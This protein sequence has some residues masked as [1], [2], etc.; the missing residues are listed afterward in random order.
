MS[1][2][3]LTDIFGILGVVSSFGS[4]LA[5]IPTFIEIFKGKSTLMFSIIPYVTTIVANIFWV[6]FGMENFRKNISLI[7]ANAIQ[8]G[9]QIVYILI[10]MYYAREKRSN[11]F[12]IIGGLVFT[13]TTVLLSYFLSEIFQ[14]SFY[15]FIGLMCTLL[16][17]LSYASP[18]SVIK[19]VFLKKSSAPIPF[20][21]SLVFLFSAIIW[22]TYAILLKN[23]NILIP[24]LCG[25]VLCLVQVSLFLIFPRNLDKE[26]EVPAEV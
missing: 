16:C 14:P 15:F 20:C 18:L 12:K 10:F 26:E 21:M 5:P 9:F 1:E 13:V 24:N 23:L 6:L 3:L 7:L 22:T 11:F 19:I 25:V 8:I 2:E 4:N 17:I